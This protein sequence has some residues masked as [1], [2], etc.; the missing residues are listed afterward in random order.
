VILKP[1]IDLHGEPKNWHDAAPLYIEALKDI[2]EA[3]LAMAVR[4]AIAANPYFP[5]P[6]ELRASVANELGEYRRRRE[7]AWRASLPKPP[8]PPP[9]SPED[10]AYVAELLAPM[11]R[12]CPSTSSSE[13]D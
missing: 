13:E 10:I 12:A 5:K 11:R 1:L 6:A 7:E 3:I 8:E 2:P 9:P 4:H